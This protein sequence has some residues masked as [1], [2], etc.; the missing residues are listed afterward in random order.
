MRPSVG[1]MRISLDG[2][3]TRCLTR[4]PPG[5]SSPTARWAPCCRRP[6]SAS[7]TSRGYEGCNEVLNVTR[8]EVVRC[9]ARRLLRRRRR[10]RRD[11]H[12]RHQPRQPR[13]VRHPAPDRGAGR[14]RRPD[15][16]RS[17]PTTGRRRTSRASCSARS[18]RAPSCRRSDTAAYDTLREAYLR[19]RGRPVDRR[20]RRADRGDLPGPAPG[21]VRGGRR[22]PG[23]GRGWA[24]GAVDLPRH[25]R[26]HRHDA[27]R[28]RDRRRADRAR[29]ARHRPDR[30]QLRHR[31]GG[32]ERAP[33]LPVPARPG[34]AV[35]D[36]ERRPAAA[37]R[38]RRVL[39]ADAGRVGR[40]AGPVRQRVRRRAG[41]RL[42]RHH[43]RSTSGWSPSA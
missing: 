43:A 22:P 37:H 42:L 7:T 15:R 11:Q 41:R 13:R 16:P 18:G 3:R 5:S 29:A 20:R 34:T 28:Q 14:G 8:P 17:R 19:E 30:A 6:T 9:G 32:D 23:D 36:A 1:T 38:G 40:G 21:Q 10:L 33:A 12:L 27:A 2:C 31:A 35:G 24:Y 26:D 25:R 39:P 4:S